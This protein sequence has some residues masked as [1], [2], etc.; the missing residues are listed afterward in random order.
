P[1]DDPAVVEAVRY[2]VNRQE[3]VDKITFGLAEPTT[4]PFPSR[5]LAYDPQSADLWPYDPDRARQI[6][7]DA[8]YAPGDIRAE[9]VARAEDP[10][11]EVIQSQ[12]GAIGITVDIR[13]SPDWATP[14]FAKD[15]ALSW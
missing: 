9:L 8:G 4:Q 6:L 13:V 10:Q 5:Y 3:F 11:S 15:L 12:L 1:F 7:A 2:A 14:F